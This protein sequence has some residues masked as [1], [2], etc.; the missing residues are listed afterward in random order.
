MGLGRAPGGLESGPGEEEEEA[1]D[2]MDQGELGLEVSRQ[3][4][5]DQ[6]I[7][8][9]HPMVMGAGPQG[10]ELSDWATAQG[11]SWTRAMV[12][13]RSFSQANSQGEL[14]R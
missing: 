11:Q 10:E 6:P 7:R 5:R 12:G 8:T 13:W 9:C 14:W 2:P 1:V 4:T 3:A